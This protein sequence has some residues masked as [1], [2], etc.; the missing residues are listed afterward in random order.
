MSYITCDIINF[1]LLLSFR[2]W[3]SGGLGSTGLTV[4]IDDL[5]GLF[6]PK[7]FYDSTILTYLLY[8]LTI[9]KNFFVNTFALFVYEKCSIFELKSSERPISRKKSHCSEDTSAM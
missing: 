9:V 8:I 5:K 3:F 6:Q 4:A 7:E 1:I 2:I